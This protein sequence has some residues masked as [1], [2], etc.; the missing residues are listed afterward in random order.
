[1][2][3]VERYVIGV[4]TC[5]FNRHRRRGHVCSPLKSVE[6]LACRQGKASSTGT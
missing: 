2:R 1:V 4:A 5:R 3:M 6:Q